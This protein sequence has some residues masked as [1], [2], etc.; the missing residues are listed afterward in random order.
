ML[1]TVKKER[2]QF[3]SCQFKVRKTLS[4]VIS[5]SINLLVSYV[6]FFGLLPTLIFHKTVSI[7]CIWFARVW[8]CLVIVSNLVLHT[9]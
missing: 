6:G 7:F 5:R 3:L 4:F 2:L 1:V 8:V 9:F